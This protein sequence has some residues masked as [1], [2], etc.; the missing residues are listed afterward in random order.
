[1]RKESSNQFTEG[2]VCDLNPI[3]TP[4]TVLTDN[5]NGTIIT[6]DGN[7]FSLQ[8]D[9][10]NYEL[11]NCRLKPN[12]IP[13]GVKEYGDILYIVSYNP[14]DDH[15]EVGSY[16]SPLNVGP[17]EPLPSNVTFES[18]LKD[19]VENQEQSS[20]YSD[21]VK[22]EKQII[23]SGDDYKLYPGDEYQLDVEG[24]QTYLFENV[25]YFILDDSSILHDITSEIKTNS[26]FKHVSWLIPGWLVAK[27]RLAKL[28]GS[29]LNIK[30]FYAPL[31]NGKRNV[32]YDFNFKINI[33]DP[34]IN[35]LLNEDS[36]HIKD[37]DF[38]VKIKNN[39][40]A[41]GTTKLNKSVTKWYLDNNIVWVNCVGKLDCEEKDTI[42]IQTTPTLT[43]YE[44]LEDG[45]PSL[46][47][48][49]YDN[50][51]QT[52]EFNLDKI[53]DVP[54]AIDDDY[55]KF[56]QRDS[57]EQTIEVKITGPSITSSKVNLNYQICNIDDETVI[58]EGSF[59]DYTGIGNNVL[60]IPFD[61]NFI[62]ENIYILKFI[63]D[64]EE[65]SLK[66]EGEKL[67]ICTKLLDGTE[68][69]DN[70]Q[71]KA[72]NHIAGKYLRDLTI[73]DNGL[74]YTFDEPELSDKANETVK[75]FLSND[76][77]NCFIPVDEDLGNSVD[78]NIPYNISFIEKN[79]KL[80]NNDCLLSQYL[81]ITRT[82]NIDGDEDD[83]S[84]PIKSEASLNLLLSTKQHGSPI[85][86]TNAE[87]KTLREYGLIDQGNI[88]AYTLNINDD[89]YYY[90]TGG[91]ELNI[92]SEGS[93]SANSDLLNIPFTQSGY[94]ASLDSFPYYKLKL[95][96]PKTM[97]V[98]AS[99]DGFKGDGQRWS[100][101]LIVFQKKTAYYYEDGAEEL[102]K[103]FDV[104]YDKNAKIINVNVTSGE[105]ENKDINIEGTLKTTFKIKDWNS[106]WENNNKFKENLIITNNDTTDVD[107]QLSEKYDLSW[108][109]DKQ[110]EYITDEKVS[111]TLIKYTDSLLHDQL[112]EI[113]DD[114]INISG[115]Y[116]NNES[117]K[118]LT[119]DGHLDIAIGND[120]HGAAFEVSGTPL[121]ID[122]N[123]TIGNYVSEG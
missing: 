38:I 100:I 23:F 115:V 121:I 71:V 85:R 112:N 114:V 18:I 19:V 93:L 92:Y 73:K 40:G 46:Y 101:D 107:D 25:E 51:T 66:S 54:F 27:I 58:K 99:W 53:D 31:K 1:M 7:E 26:E 16:P 117:T 94:S 113:R 74:Q 88:P 120:I 2:L 43:Q 34:I 39:G 78:V 22:L 82:Y 80:E 123:I 49:V 86:F 50:L 95:T 28:S 87:L 32:S 84:L 83:L 42:T 122:D 48:I 4:N 17:K 20:N 45:A 37:L 55:Y 13:V 15:V 70:Y 79:F 14:L 10:G 116:Y 56:Y 11:K 102:L 104:I 33:E 68:E 5:I 12:Y 64:S 103:G 72:I 59:I 119:L 75:K 105:L 6:Y 21:L 62:N 91:R 67:L 89:L 9:L 61:D 24:L 65:K 97:E 52:Q 76:K 3:N 110:N 106:R 60:T 47:T 36:D 29:E 57:N 108:W 44:Y 111:D 69:F 41:E 30:T 96:V 109:V 98:N 77:Y 63:F 90:F 118:N 81:N 35:K 8:N